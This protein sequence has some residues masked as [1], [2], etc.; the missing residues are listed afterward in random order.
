MRAPAESPSASLIGRTAS[1]LAGASGTSGPLGENDN[2]RSG[3]IALPADEPTVLRVTGAA[4][5][6]GEDSSATTAMAATAPAVITPQR[7]LP[8]V[9]APIL[10]LCRLA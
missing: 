7:R 3:S 5:D 1:G 10:L 6:F 4:A 8:A 9:I 2:P